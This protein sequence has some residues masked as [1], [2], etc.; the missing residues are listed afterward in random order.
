M[1]LIFFLY[2][3]K[4]KKIKG[5]HAATL[6]GYSL[7]AKDPIPYGPKGFLSRASRI[8]RIYAHDD[9]VGP[10]ARMVLD[11]K[12]ITLEV[13]KD[14]FVEMDSL[15]TSWQD[16][17]GERGNIRALPELVLIPLYNKIRLPFYLINGIVSLFD[18]YIEDIRCDIPIPSNRPEWDIH[19]TTVND[20]KSEILMSDFFKNQ[21]YRLE[22]LSKG[23]PRFIWRAIAWDSGE[24]LIELLFDATDIEQS[25]FFI[26]AI[27]HNEHFSVILR[28]PLKDPNFIET[29]R[30]K[31]QWKILEWFEENPLL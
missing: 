17:E 21:E 13:K 8:D 11:G 25:P 9:Q 15:S 28:Q 27:E 2:N 16:E 26:C 14:E 24:R 18:N 19:L 4:E 22:I 6:T 5:R 10:F 1:V 30:I 23:M 31:P 3:E 29:L 7:G 12:K 20:L